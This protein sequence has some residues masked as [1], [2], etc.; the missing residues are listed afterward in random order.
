MAV[1]KW[2]AGKMIMTK[3][4]QII[5]FKNDTFETTDPDIIEAFEGEKEITEVKKE[6]PTKS[7]S[8]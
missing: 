7:K 3:K 6:K 2:K 8:E 5:R 4:A 1:F